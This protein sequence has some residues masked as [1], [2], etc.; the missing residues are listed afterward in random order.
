E[1]RGSLVSAA[2]ASGTAKQGQSLN[3][4]SPNTVKLQVKREAWYRVSAQELFNAGL[5]PSAEPRAV[6]LFVDGKQQ[7]ISITGQDDGRLDPEDSVEFY[8]MG[9]DSPYSDLR[10]YYLV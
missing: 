5:D 9:I 2:A 10:T 4:S 8:G 3:A 6:Q 1:S 7:A